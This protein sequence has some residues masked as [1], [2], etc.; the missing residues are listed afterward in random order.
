V[1][2]LCEEV[3]DRLDSSSRESFYHHERQ[4][5]RL[6][7]EFDRRYA[8]SGLCGIFIRAESLAGR[9]FLEAPKAV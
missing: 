7:A 1:T 9:P 3:E 8:G 4:L 2:F 6:Y 5:R